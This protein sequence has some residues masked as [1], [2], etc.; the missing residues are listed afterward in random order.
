MHLLY[1]MRIISQPLLKCPTEITEWRSLLRS[2]ILQSSIRNLT[3]QV[4]FQA[5]VVSGFDQI[6][7]TK[8][9]VNFQPLRGSDIQTPLVAATAGPKRTCTASSIQGRQRP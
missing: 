2:S 1:E 4:I 8:G 9:K 3:D 7:Q 6:P 5:R